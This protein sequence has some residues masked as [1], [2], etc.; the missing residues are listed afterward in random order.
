[1]FMHGFVGGFRAG[2]GFVADVAGYGLGGFQRGGE[3]LAGLPDLFPGHI[4]GGRHQ[5]LR[6]FGQLSNFTASSLCLF[7]HKIDLADGGGSM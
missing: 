6:V 5:R 4:G 3:T 7:V 2:D 1:M